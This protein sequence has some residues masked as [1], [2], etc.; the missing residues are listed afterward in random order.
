MRF[1]VLCIALAALAA[2]PAC[3]CGTS[4]TAG[5]GETDLDIDRTDDSTGDVDADPG[6]DTISD[7]DAEADADTVTGPGIVLLVP[8]DGSEHACASDM[9]VEWNYYGLP[10]GV[11]FTITLTSAADPGGG[12]V[13]AENVEAAD[14]T[15]GSAAVSLSD[16]LITGDYVVRVEAQDTDPVVF[17][18]SDIIIYGIELPVYETYVNRT[19]FRPGRDLIGMPRKVEGDSGFEQ[20]VFLSWRMLVGDDALVEYEVR[21]GDTFDADC[22]SSSYVPVATTAVNNYLDSNVEPGD[23]TFYCIRT[24]F[25]G[26][27]LDVFSNI[28]EVEA[29]GGSE[30]YN[31][32]QG[33]TITLPVGGSCASHQF[34]LADA[35]VPGDLDGNGT[36][37]LVVRFCDQDGGICNGSDFFVEAFLRNDRG[38][39][40][41]A[42]CHETGSTRAV[43]IVW[44]LDLDGRAEVITLDDNYNMIVALDGESGEVVASGSNEASA[45][46]DSNHRWYTRFNV[47]Y[48]NGIRP[49]LVAQNNHFG[50]S[51]EDNPILIGSLLSSGGAISGAQQ[52]AWDAN[53]GTHGLP[54]ADLDSDGRD[55]IV[56]CGKALRLSSGELVELWTIPNSYAENHNDTC[57]PGDII[58]AAAGLETFFGIERNRDRLEGGVGVIK[59]DG[60]VAW[61]RPNSYFTSGDIDAE[62]RGWEKGTC[63]ESD[64]SSSGMECFCYE[65]CED[66]GCMG[67][68]GLDRDDWW[69][70][71]YIFAGIDGDVLE[72][73]P[74]RENRTTNRTGIDWS[75]GDGVVELK[76]GGL[77]TGLFHQSLDFVGDSR[78][79]I[80]ELGGDAMTIHINAAPMDARYLAPIYDPNYFKPMTQR[81]NGGYGYTSASHISQTFV[82]ACD[83]GPVKDIDMP[84]GEKISF[85]C[86]IG[87]L[88]GFEGQVA[89]GSEAVPDSVLVAF[90]PGQDESLA[91]DIAAGRSA[92]LRVFVTTDAGLETGR[93]RFRLTA[94]SSV[95]GF[96]FGRKLHFILDIG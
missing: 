83:V 70:K 39:W 62:F 30:P 90:G 17:D 59:A 45:A 27:L 75:G 11:L 92:L 53:L 64:L 7:P 23:S 33:T 61:S 26:A 20:V 54:V 73:W 22:G 44:D 80:V 1:L 52:F 38:R 8:G 14:A 12:L 58:P 57:F 91:L 42:W 72:E 55:E 15:S 28:V 9:S 2:A 68:Q 95:D 51:E 56:A 81:A 50:G 67:R 78:E 21:R 36:M 63:F 25:N 5:D 76:G 77:G 10:E 82:L 41:P 86:G 96:S 35:V 88:Q 85:I 46:G 37:D 94:A 13:M 71:S 16:T 93:Y 31:E 79:E 66:R 47:A 29:R 60:E 74:A 24:V 4:E 69:T 34:T 19:Y 3:S 49:Y 89:I 87:S 32:G 84:A 6:I 40:E 48:L 18:E 65:F 43:V